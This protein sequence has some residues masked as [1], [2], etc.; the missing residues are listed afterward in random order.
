VLDVLGDSPGAIPSFV[1]HLNGYLHECKVSERVPLIGELTGDGMERQDAHQAQAKALSIALNRLFESIHEEPEKAS[2]VV[3]IE[4][5]QRREM[6]RIEAMREAFEAEQREL[7]GTQASIGVGDYEPPTWDDTHEALLESPEL[8]NTLIRWGDAQIKDIPDVWMAIWLSFASIHAPPIR[9]RD[10]KHWP[11]CDVLL[12][13]EI[14]TAKSGVLSIVRD[15]TPKGMF[16]TNFTPVAF[17]GRVNK[18]GDYL[19]G[20]AYRANGGVLCIDELDKL[21]KRYPVLD[22]L[23]RSAQT[24]HNV[25]HDTAFGEVDHE[26]TLGIVAGANPKG[27]I[28]SDSAIRAQVPFAEGLLSRYA[29]IKPLAYTPE[30]VNAIVG[31]MADTWFTDAPPENVLDVDTIRSTLAALWHRLKDVHAVN[32][33]L[34]LRRALAERFVATQD[35]VAGMP[36]LTSRDMESAFKWLNASASLHV[37]QRDVENGVIKAT[38]QDLD[39]AMTMLDACIEVRRAMLSTSRSRVAITPVERAAAILKRELDGSELERT[40][41]VALL[42]E[43]L[44][45]SQATAYRYLDDL[46]RRGEI[47][48]NGRY[49]SSIGLAPA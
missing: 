4:Y 8:L 17:T 2:L 44:D 27:D 7:Y 5:H 16:K 42:M 33:P 49:K 23:I 37:A 36:L 11:Q 28:F 30:K 12:V 15:V 22:G 35:D 41:A 40:D 46:A 31:F 48:K 14:S 47:V 24:E 13:G 19:P 39:N 38:T 20:I 43:R 9:Q 32:V 25:Q 18:D 45:I 3:P 29:F 21:L 1:K 34:E 6:E 10:Q 26:T